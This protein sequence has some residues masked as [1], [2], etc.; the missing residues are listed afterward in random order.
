MLCIPKKTLDLILR[1][2]CHFLGQVK[3]NCPAL[4]AQVA[5]FTALTQPITSCEYYE[6]KHGYQVNRQVEL[7]VNKADLPKGWNGIQ[8]LVKVRRYGIRDQKEFHEVS[9]YILSK[10]L[11]S[12]AM[13]AKAI[14][15][16][17]S[18]ENKL[19]WIKD[20][21]LGE[22]DMTLSQPKAAIILA[23]LNNTAINVLRKAGRKPTKDT[24]AQISNKVK[25]LV[26]LFKNN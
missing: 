10:P 4:Y 1:L 22:D 23:Y 16:H 21:N 13:V 19:H 7:Y 18:I 17:W 20:V 8:R 15:G 9:F 5:L 2:D 24:F 12:A 26:K 14:Q 6:D 25:E 3:A 11:N